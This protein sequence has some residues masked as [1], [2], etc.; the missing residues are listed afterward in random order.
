MQS[1]HRLA[2]VGSVSVLLLW[3]AGQ[4]G[5]LEAPEGWL[6]DRMVGWSLHADDADSRVLLV[7]VDRS[8]AKRISGELHS[9]IGKLERLGAV[10]VALGFEPEGTDQA[11]FQQ[12]VAWGNVVFGCSPE[13]TLGS[14]RYRLSGLSDYLGGMALPFGVLAVPPRRARDPSSGDVI[15][16]A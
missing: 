6:Y 13:P 16:R 10:Q 3:V 8:D 4:A 11:L 7:E 9:L 5:F 15:G 14:D 1:F 12:A 2:V